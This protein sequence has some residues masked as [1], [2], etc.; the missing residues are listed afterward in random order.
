MKLSDYDYS[1][2][3]SF[4]AHHPL[5]ERDESRLLV[6]SSKIEHKK[7]K[8][9]VDYFSKGDVLVLNDSKVF[10][11]KLVGK[12]ETGGKIEVLLMKE[13]APLKWECLA[14]GRKLEGKTVHFGNF[15]G[16]ISRE[17]WRV[18]ITFSEKI[19][20]HKIGKPPLPPY[21]K[22]EARLERYNTVYSSQE[23]SIAAPTAGL[24]FTEEVLDKLKQK[25]VIIAFVT[26]HIGLG[27]FLPVKTETI[28]DHDMHS[29][30]F[31]ISKE[32][33]RAINNRNGG[34]VVVGTSTLRALESAT[35]EEIVHPTTKTT[36]LFIHP[37]YRWKLTYKGL[38]TNFHLPKSTLLMLV[39][40]FL[41]KNKIKKAYKEAKK[42]Q[43]RFYSFGD[44]MLILKK[45][46][47]R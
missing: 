24:H 34:L 42:R 4:I 44:A 7:F 13:V 9:I 31:S 14:Q 29:E 10:P 39:S 45:S 20:L 6:L 47:H 28:T 18:F 23:G 16:K 8:D 38:I 19:P 43:Y 1:L 3:K 33:A 2:E 36:K 26:L 37:P 32:T 11:A 40:A 46:T 21:I 27:T 15:T 41:N 25:G 30:W 35:E 22:G 17:K 5:E 12:K